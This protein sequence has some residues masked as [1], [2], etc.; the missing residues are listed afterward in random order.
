[1]GCGAGC[2]GAGCWGAGCGA[3]AEVVGVGAGLGVLVPT[4]SIV[5]SRSLACLADAIGSPMALIIITGGFLTGAG[6]GEMTS[7]TALP[8]APPNTL[9]TPLPILPMPPG[10]GLLPVLSAS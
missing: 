10:A 6:A 7:T 1:V 9:P 8:A 2:C 3:G 5:C 4:F